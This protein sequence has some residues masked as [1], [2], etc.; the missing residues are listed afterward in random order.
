MIES[1]LIEELVAENT[2]ET[3]QRAILAFLDARFGAVP[4]DL[5]DQIRAVSEEDRLSDLVRK[6][7]SCGDLESFRNLLRQ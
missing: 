2:R 1:P 5:A 7:G 6:A 3:M 4:Q